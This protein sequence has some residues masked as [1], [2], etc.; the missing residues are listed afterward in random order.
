[1]RNDPWPTRIVAACIAGALLAGC[2]KQRNVPPPVPPPAQV[3][4]M[5]VIERT[6]IVTGELVG[7]V[8]AYREVPLRPQVSG[9]VQKILFQ[10]GQRVRENQPLFVI[11]PRPYEATLSEALG[12]IVDAEAALARARQDVA[13]YEPLLPDNAIPRATYDAAVAA[14]KSAQAALDQRR[15][16]AAR[17]RLDVSNTQ[18][19]SPVTGLIGLQQIEIGGLATAGQTVLATVSTLDP[20]YVNF[21]VPEADYVRFMRSSGSTE[22]AAR[23]ARANRFQLILPDGSPYAE[24]GTFDFV[25]R[26]VTQ[27]TGTLAVRAKFPNPQN[28]LRTGMNV[29]VRLTLDEIPGAMLVPQRAVTEI[30]GRQFVTVLGAGDK[31]EQRAVTLGERVGTLWIVKSGLKSG[32]R[33]V[34][35]GAQKAPAGATVVPTT[36]AEAQLDNPPA[37]PAPASASPAAAPGKPAPKP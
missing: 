25:E 22:A 9:I 13:R 27:A 30:L 16:V 5:H 14:A 11:D 24:Q 1:M 36:I 18:V 37:L 19:L 17:V 35:D 6:A 12:G 15:A 7:Q 8:S 4:A 33:I 26:A 29:R 2:S 21:S 28:L 23:E 31:A 32:E 3:L 20:V 10:P 34:V